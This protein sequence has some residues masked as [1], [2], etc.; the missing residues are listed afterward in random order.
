MIPSQ[1]NTYSGVEPFSTKG[2]C[3]F[4][5][6]NNQGEFIKANTTALKLFGIEEN[7][8]SKLNIFDF[9]HK[10]CHT[11][12]KEA[13]ENI[14][15][16]NIDFARLDLILDSNKPDSDS[17]VYCLDINDL[18][19]DCKILHLFSKPTE[20]ND[21]NLRSSDFEALFSLFDNSSTYYWVLNKNLEFIHA[22]DS[23]IQAFLRFYS[24]AWKIGDSFSSLF[25]KDKSN[26]ASIW[27]E[28]CEHVLRTG[29]SQF[30]EIT[31]SSDAGFSHIKVELHALKSNAEINGVSC[32]V[33]DDSDSFLKNK[34][35]LALSRFK[36]KLIRTVSINDLLW[37]ITDEVLSNLYL[38]DAI[39]LM[40]YNN[41]LQSKAAYGSKRKGDK[42]LDGLLEIPVG[43]GVVGNVALNG[44]ATIVND[45]KSNKHYFKDHFDA[46][47]EIAVPI[48][49]DKKV[50]GVINCESSFKNFFEPIHLEILTEVAEVTA[51]RINQIVTERKYRKVQ[52]LNRAVLNSTPASYF[53]L[54]PNKEII[55]FNKTAENAM[56]S[57]SGKDVEVGLDF[58]SL[59]L[60]SEKDEFVMLFD[61][62]L[63]GELIKQERETTH[64]ETGLIWIKTTFAPAINEQEKV[65]GVT[66]IIENITKDKESEELILEQ[67]K[68][69]TKTNKELDKFI[70]SVSHDLRSPVSSVMGV[71]TLIGLTDDVDEIKEYNQL[72]SGSMQR[73]DDFIRNILDYSRNARI[74]VLNEEVDIAELINGIVTDHSYMRE[75]GDIEV[76]K[77]VSSDK[78]VTD[79]QRLSIVLSNLVSNA[80]KYHDSEKENQFIK[81]TAF[82]EEDCFR[83][84]VKDNG[85]GIKEEHLPKLFDMFY[86]VSSKAKGS[87][88]GLYILKDTISI[89]QGE[90]SVHSEYGKGT[91]FH[92]TL[93]L[94]LKG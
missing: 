62:A 22:N 15:A 92:V 17:T 37:S 53:L 49:L 12:L 75:I 63:N 79:R 57:F 35:Q 29:E 40:K 50:I 94:T 89:L 67:N 18:D 9:A 72:I 31:E 88:I 80:I 46:S 27:L 10:D 73:M 84:I 36:S 60:D 78:I 70:Y 34:L 58:L 39:I 65:F 26:N 45:T 7:T 74:Q 20:Y 23:S 86:T 66:L 54:N 51:E 76:L 82:S 59:V 56:H 19:K 61:K 6:I 71:T 11:S 85:L 52:E 16:G 44:K 68:R 90:I 48:I 30:F 41:V 33:N 83:I 77:E 32:L 5:I 28:K 14:E 91:E 25:D 87:G 42:R 93:P 81:L 4:L 1:R 21:L 3:A 38:E 43:Q 47:S 13:L 8:L 24:Y 2:S 64:P 55:S 69:L